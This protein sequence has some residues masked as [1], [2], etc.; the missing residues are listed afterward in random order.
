MSGRFDALAA[1]R[2]QPEVRVDGERP[3][4]DSEAGAARCAISFH[5]LATTQEGT[6]SALATAKRLTGGLD[7]RV[8]LLVPRLTPL[9]A[10]FDP[11]SGESG[12]LL[13]QHRRLAAEVGVHVN[14][15]FCVCHRR[16]DIVHQ[17]L[18][19]SSLVIVGGRKR[20]WWPS[21]EQ[22]L[23]DRLIGEGYAV[24]FARVS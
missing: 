6:R 7:A 20:A 17:M 14:V 8:V 5:V 18:G 13:D 10:R 15:M 22:R 3:R 1:E 4:Q 16:A 23:A 11:T 24:V 2:I 21:R 9:L 19:R 12:A